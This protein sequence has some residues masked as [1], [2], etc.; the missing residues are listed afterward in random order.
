MC[1]YITYH[2]GYCYDADVNAYPTLSLQGKIALN[3]Y[4]DVLGTPY[5][6]NKLFRFIVICGDSKRAFEIKAPDQ[7]SKTQWLQAIKKVLLNT[8]CFNRVFDG[9][10]GIYD[11]FNLTAQQ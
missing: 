7:N 3:Y 2:K 1:V 10:I 4:S 6:K 9:F 8:D 5:E 11:C